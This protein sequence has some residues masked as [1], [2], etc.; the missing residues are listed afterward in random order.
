[1]SDSLIQALPDLVAFV[2]RDGVI[3][4]CLGGRR[5]TDRP[6]PELLVGRNI[7]ET[8]LAPIA[9]RLTQMLRKALA[10]RVNVTSTY[11]DGDRNYEARVSPEGRER[12]LC[13]IRDLTETAEAAGTRATDAPSAAAAGGM[14]KV[15]VGERGTEGAEYGALAD[16]G[17]EGFDGIEDA[18][19][20]RRARIL[21][22]EVPEVRHHPLEQ[23]HLGGA[24]GAALEV[25][26]ERPGL[27]LGEQA[28]QVILDPRDVRAGA[29]GL[30]SS[31]SRSRASNR[32]LSSSR[33]RWMR[34]LTVPRGRCSASA[35]S[36]YDRS[37]WCRSTTTIR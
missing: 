34:A 31:S 16:S 33:A 8:W 5:L 26:A 36:S 25:G 9:P 35:I 29:H 23:G 19:G 37:C 20:E 32:A 24:I 1:M 14:E 3:T 6:D 7:T 18:L 15:H 12:V 28:F 11:V 13:V 27:A 17:H 10:S 21:D 22:R 4:A 2:R 30:F